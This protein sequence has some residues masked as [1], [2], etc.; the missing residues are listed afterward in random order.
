LTL[1]SD[2]PADER[3]PH[4]MGASVRT[5]KGGKAVAFRQ[6]VDTVKVRWLS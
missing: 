6:H 2:P 3:L 4:A 5:M 1:I